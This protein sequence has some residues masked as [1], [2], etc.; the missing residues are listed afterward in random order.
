MRSRPYEWDESRLYVLT[1]QILTMAQA[2]FKGAW[3]R[4]FLGHAFGEA[5]WLRRAWRQT[6][7]RLAKD[8]TD[9]QCSHWIETAFLSLEE[10]VSHAVVSLFCAPTNAN[11]GQSI[12]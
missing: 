12:V 2:L 3:R 5:W 10:P 8:S 6:V 9:N 7:M 4:E 11:K 1:L